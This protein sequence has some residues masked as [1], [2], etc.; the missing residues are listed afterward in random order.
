MECSGYFIPGLHGVIYPIGTVPGKPSTV[1][2][3][4]GAEAGSGIGSSRRSSESWMRP[5]RSIGSS[6]ALTAVAS[7]HTRPQ[8]APGKKPRAGEPADHALGRSR[9]GWGSKLHLVSDGKGLVLTLELSA[10]QENE[11]THATSVLDGVR[12]TRL[13]G[14]PRQRPAA[15]AGDKGYSSRAIRA[16]LRAK[17]VRAAIPERRDQIAHRKGRPRKFDRAA[18]RRRN[19]IERAVGWLKECR[20]LA[21]R[22][23]K[24]A[25]QF[26]AMLKLAMIEQH[27][28]RYLSNTA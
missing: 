21:T 12:I 10:G 27:M 8:Q 18:Y 9:G 28:Q 5:A 4:A 11:C 14:R 16:W 26:L 25:T 19:V 20:R 24:L 6:S 15:V 1:G 2:F 13:R 3:C 22:F 23:E 17:K 7:A